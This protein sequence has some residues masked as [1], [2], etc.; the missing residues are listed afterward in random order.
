M[1]ARTWPYGTRKT[2]VIIDFN[3]GVRTDAMFL[4]GDDEPKEGYMLLDKRGHFDGL[5]RGQPVTIEFKPGGET[6]GYWDVVKE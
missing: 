2:G 4:V 5:K 3:R 1:I 6:G